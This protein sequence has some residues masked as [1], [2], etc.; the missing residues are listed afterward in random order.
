MRHRRARALRHDAIGDRL[1]DAGQAG[2]RTATATRTGRARRG[3]W[4][5]MLFVV[6]GSGVIDEA[7]TTLL[8][9][10]A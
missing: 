2:A 1:A 8:N 5:A 3:R 9:A 4:P 6:L 7:T 10:P